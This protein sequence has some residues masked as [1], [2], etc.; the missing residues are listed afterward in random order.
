MGLW[1]QYVVATLHSGNVLRAGCNWDVGLGRSGKDYDPSRIRR[2][3]Y[4][5][6]LAGL[7]V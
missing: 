2:I 1:K 5:E 6:Y 4:D 3:M 7:W